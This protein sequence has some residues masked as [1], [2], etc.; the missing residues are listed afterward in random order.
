MRNRLEIE[1]LMQGLYAARKRGDF[2]GVS[3]CFAE[4]AKFQIASAKEVSALAV[5]TS[6]AHEFRP[7][8]AFLIKTFKLIDMTII[9]IV[10]DD[11]K[12]AVHWRANVHSKITGAT[13]A[14]E[15]VDLVEFQEGMIVSYI[16]F[17][18]HL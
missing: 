9:S 1:R 8:L 4:L 11:A 12:A 14:T 16:E 13:V 3:Q 2:K 5:T 7:L 10:I 15:F 6:S 17:F 18:V